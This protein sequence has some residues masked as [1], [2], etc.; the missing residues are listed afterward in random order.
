MRKKKGISEPEGYLHP[1]KE[2][3]YGNVNLGRRKEEFNYQVILLSTLD[4]SKALFLQLFKKCMK[5]LITHKLK[6]P[7]FRPS[8]LFWMQGDERLKNKV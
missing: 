2:K 4:R 8:I 5:M 6:F 3:R 7:N 1:C